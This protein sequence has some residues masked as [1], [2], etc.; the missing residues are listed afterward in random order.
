MLIKVANGF[1]AD[2]EKITAVKGSYV[3]DP[4]RL[5]HAERWGMEEFRGCAT[6][7]QAPS[8]RPSWRKYLRA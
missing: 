1:Y 4:G 7:R 5:S 8:T 6:A 2:P 3:E